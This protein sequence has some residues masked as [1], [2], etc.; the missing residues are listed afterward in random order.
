MEKEKL[1]SEINLDDIERLA[2]E[3]DEINSRQSE[4]SSGKKKKGGTR[5]EKTSDNKEDPI[6]PEII[7]P[8]PEFIF[9]IKHGSNLGV[10]FMKEQLDL[11]E[12]GATTR[13]KLGICCAR[14]AIKLTP[15]GE[16]TV[17]S[18]LACIAGYLGFWILVGRK[19]KVDQ[20]IVRPFTLPSVPP[21]VS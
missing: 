16:D 20:T 13:E 15:I 6:E 14:L 9:M 4:P 5:S 7:P 2:R 1:S 21:N 17:V 11:I 10:D 12:P 18:N 3:I 19:P 8:D